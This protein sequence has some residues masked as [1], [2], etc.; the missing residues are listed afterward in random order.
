MDMHEQSKRI[1]E[2]AAAYFAAR[3][4]ES[5]AHRQERE[6]WLAADERHRL[7]Y[8]EFQRLWDHAD[9]LRNDADLK[10]IAA[11][12]RAAVRR[13]RR[14]RWIVL[15]AAATLFLASSGAMLLWF[16]SASVTL[17]YATAIGERRTET[18]ADGTRVV[19]NTDTVLETHFTRSRRDVA[20]EKG[21][22]QFDVSHDAARPFVVNAGV[23]TVTALGT[24]F[25][26]R[27][28]ATDAV[29]TLLKGSVEVVQ[30]HEQR[31]LHPDEQAQ[32][33]DD[34]GI[35]VR[36]ID[37]AQVSGWLDGW[38]RFRN[39]PLGDVVAEAN[40]YSARKLRL[41]DPKLASLPLHGN[42]HAG[43][44]ASIAAAAAQLLG[45]RMED[46]GN[47]IVLLPK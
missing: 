36:T 1:D 19:L 33:S 40:R 32:L 2:Q 41:G 9:G 11:G 45:L 25:Q 27:R 23:G 43:D 5:A 12:E 47:D 21:E 35:R 34:A 29:V 18:L 15:T 16:K 31:I 24:R 30:G 8:D 3:Q 7:A 37:P 17:R 28:D 42:F 38:L 44:S 26:V 14:S 39:A 10:A 46:R 20:L 13:T 6:A 4:F 22:A